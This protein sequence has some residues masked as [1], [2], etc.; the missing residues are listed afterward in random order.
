MIDRQLQKSNSKFKVLVTHLAPLTAATRELLKRGLA[1]EG[2]M[3]VQEGQKS[4]DFP[5]FTDGPAE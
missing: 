3:E 4:K 2:F 5:V 1:A